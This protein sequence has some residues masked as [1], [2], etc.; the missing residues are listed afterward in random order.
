MIKKLFVFVFLG[1]VLAGGWLYD[2]ATTPLPLPSKTYDFELKSGESLKSVARRLNE[3]GVLPHPW[4][5]SI[6]SRAMGKQSGLKAGNYELTAGMSPWGLLRK[7]VRGDVTQ[8]G[9]RI[10]EGWSFRQ[11][12]AALD[13]A[14]NL[15]HDTQGMSDADIMKAVGASDSHAEGMFFPDT[16]FYGNGASDLSILKRSYAIMQRH[17]QQAW[18]GRD[19]AVPYETPYQAL[20]MASI[21]EKETGQAAERP[22]I[23]AVFIN[24]LRLGMRLQTDPTVI[25]GLGERYDGNLHKRD[26]LADTPYNTYTRGGLPPTPI[27]LP[28]KAALEA[29]LHP[30]DSQALYFVAKGNGTHKFSNSLAEHNAAVAHYQLGQ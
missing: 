3:A 27:A 24:R 23:A 13:H 16:Y 9:V 11:M 28:G 21:V 25:Y 7:L 22:L 30:A 5:F 2:Y 4:A 17:L 29:A 8:Q 12:R 14:E 26:L 6:L 10:I 19:P 20:I 1:A 18:D 15:K